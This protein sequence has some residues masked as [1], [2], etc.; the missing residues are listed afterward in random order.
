VH[1]GGRL[2]SPEGRADHLL[3]SIATTDPPDV[4]RDDLVFPGGTM[5]LISRGG[6]ITSFSINPHNCMITLKLQ[7][8]GEITGGTGQ[9]AG[10]TGSFPSAQPKREGLGPAIP[11]AAAP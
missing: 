7:N 8:P 10:A 5:H 1:S 9:F 4:S 3:A 2:Q 6:D 11:T